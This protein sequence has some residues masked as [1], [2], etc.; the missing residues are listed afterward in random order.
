[1]YSNIKDIVEVSSS[2][3]PCRKDHAE[4][5]LWAMPADLKTALKG[6]AL[7][8]V[9]FVPGKAKSLKGSMPL[10]DSRIFT[11]FTVY[12][13]YPEAY[14]GQK[15]ID[16]VLDV[17][18]KHT[19][20]PR[21]HKQGEGVEDAAVEFPDAHTA[22]LSYTLEREGFGKIPISATIKYWGRE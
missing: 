10:R 22:K 6:S 13:G 16:E 7:R 15:S 20:Q 3:L 11:D 2:D 18:E 4:D 9:L 12:L 21:Y 14:T 5:A 1:M 17:G 8:K 19:R